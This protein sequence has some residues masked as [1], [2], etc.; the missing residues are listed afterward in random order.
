MVLHDLPLALR[1]ADDVAL[2]SGGQLAVCGTVEEVHAS[3]KIDEVF[4]IALRRM[5]TESGWQYY[6]G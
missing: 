6:Y 2:L 3:G 4:G 1:G 5:E